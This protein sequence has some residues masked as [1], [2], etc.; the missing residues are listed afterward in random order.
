MA[1]VI[2]N[3]GKAFST[4][5]LKSV[6]EAQAVELICSEDANTVR[7]VW[8]IAN[9]FSVPNYLE[10]EEEDKPKKRPRKKKEPVKVEKKDEE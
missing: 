2:I 4:D 1:K 5:W 10:G 9:G 7:K 3:A 8:K 6:T